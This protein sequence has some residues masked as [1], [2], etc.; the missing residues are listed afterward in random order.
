MKTMNKE[1]E[2]IELLKKG[3]SYTYIQEVL[4]VSPSK[5]AMMKKKLFSETGNENSS[6][7]SSDSG[8]YQ[9][10]TTNYYDN[11]ENACF[12]EK[13]SNFTTE[14]ENNENRY[15]KKRTMENQN[16]EVEKLKLELNHNLE[17]KKLELQQESFDIQKRDLEMKKSMLDLEKQKVEKEG[18]A[19]IYRFRKLMLKCKKGKMTYRQLIDFNIHLSDLSEAIEEYCFKED[20]ETEDLSILN[21]LNNIIETYQDYHKQLICSY[22][23]ECCDCEDFGDCEDCDFEIE[24]SEADE[25]QI[26]ITIDPEIQQMIDESQ[27]IDFYYYD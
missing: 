13:H 8:I 27:T 20:F 26:Q 24:E 17:L 14:I 18:K 11:E 12:S 19:L 23:E 16:N 4:K 6:D 15:I 3:K 2:I 1:S 25:F 22:H 5:I 10:S 7:S 21:I 9:E